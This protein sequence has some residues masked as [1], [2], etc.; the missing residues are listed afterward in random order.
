[1][2]LLLD[3]SLVKLFE[4][5]AYLRSAVDEYGACNVYV[6]VFVMSCAVRSEGESD[7]EKQATYGMETSDLPCFVPDTLPYM[8]NCYDPKPSCEH[9]RSPVDWVIEVNTTR[10]YLAVTHCENRWNSKILIE[11]NIENFW[12]MVVFIF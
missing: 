2:G 5:H 7:C 8:R 11:I 9:W 12:N 3:V 4:K 1:M 6:D 10:D